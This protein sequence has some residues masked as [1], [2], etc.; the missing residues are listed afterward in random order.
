MILVNDLFSIEKYKYAKNETN[1]LITINKI[2][3]INKINDN[4][5]LTIDIQKKIN[6]DYS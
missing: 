2:K 1:S 3:I 5:N 4:Y 6:K